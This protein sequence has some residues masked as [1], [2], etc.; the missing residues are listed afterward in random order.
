MFVQ[1]RKKQRRKRNRWREICQFKK[2]IGGNIKVDG[3]I[4][5]RKR[6]I[7]LSPIDIFPD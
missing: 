1:G 4:Q 6:P 2:K 3:L 7:G 5:R